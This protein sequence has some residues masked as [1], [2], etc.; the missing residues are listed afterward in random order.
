MVTMFLNITRMCMT[1]YIRLPFFG[2]GAMDW[3]ASTTSWFTSAL[4]ATC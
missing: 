2:L 3:A 4:T 1:Y